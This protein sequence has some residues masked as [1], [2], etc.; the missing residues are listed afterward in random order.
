MRTLITLPDHEP[1]VYCVSEWN[2][3]EVVPLVEEKSEKYDII[4]GH[5]VK[6]SVV[7]HVIKEKNP[8]FLIFNGHG[9]LSGECIYGQND[10]LLIGVGENENLLNSKIVHSFTCC[11]AKVLGEKSKPKAFIG[12]E[13]VFSFYTHRATTA[14]PL[15]DKLAAPQMISALV[16]PK[17]LLKGA[18]AK[19]AY[20]ESQKKFQE[21]ID[22]YLWNGNKYTKEE[23]DRIL[24]FLISNKRC[25][26]RIGD[27]EARA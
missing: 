21:F 2:K 15:D 20:E 18:T 14:R 4:G 7:E 25:Q 26:V 17:K 1:G 6:R 8:N 5:Q 9:S 10:E 16:A 19:E 24:P 13:N 22:E 11:S 12:Y 27:P 3:K 23:I